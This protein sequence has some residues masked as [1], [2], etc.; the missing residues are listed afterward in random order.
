MLFIK[1][2]TVIFLSRFLYRDLSPSNPAQSKWG[3]TGCRVLV[4]R[5]N[6]K[7]MSDYGTLSLTSWDSAVTPLTEEKPLPMPPWDLFI[8]GTLHCLMRRQNNKLAQNLCRDI[9]VNGRIW[10]VSFLPRYQGAVS[11]TDRTNN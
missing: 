7:I 3:P 9:G 6:P 8:C 2:C 10:I 5:C 11:R 4:K 1:V